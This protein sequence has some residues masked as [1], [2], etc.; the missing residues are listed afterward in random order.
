MSD[1][2][3]YDLLLVGGSSSNLILAHRLL[4]LAKLSGLKISIAILEK[5]R[6]FGGHIISGAI[7]NPQVIARLFPDFESQGFPHEGRVEVSHLSVLGSQERWDLPEAAIPKGLRKQGQFI[8]T[9]S[10]VIRWLAETLQ[11]KAKGIPNVTLDVF[12]GFAAHEILYE[13]ERVI[14]VRVSDS[15]QVYE[16]CVF[17]ELT[18]FGDKGFISKDLVEKFHLRPRP[19]LWSVGVKELWQIPRSLQGQVWHTLGY[20]VLDGSFSGGFVYGLKDNRLALGLIIGLDSKNPNLNPQQRLQEFKAHPWIQSLIAGGKLLKY[21]AAVIPEGGYYSLPSRFGVEG[22]LLLGDALGVLDVGSLAGINNAM[23][24]GYLAAGLIHDGFLKGDLRIQEAY[25]KAV[26]ESSV[27]QDLYRSRYFR[28]AFLENSRLLEEYLPQICRSVDAGHPWLG[29]LRWGLQDP[30][31]RGGEL[32][33]AYTLLTGRVSA[34]EPPPRGYVAPHAAIQADFVAP[35][36]LDP[37]ALTTRWGYFSRSDAVFFADPRYPEGN[38]HILEFSADTCRQ[39]IAT[40]DKLNRP[41]PCVADCT[42]EV[43]H[44]REHN[45]IRS[46]A[47]SLE[48]CIQCRTCEI[49][50]PHL[51]LRVNPSYEGSGPDFYGL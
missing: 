30:V 34:G 9:L 17:A 26:M 48:N 46:H 43:H 3:R 47:M 5:A 25:Q 39:C 6:Q 33:R 28:E 21:G 36:G 31:R 13:G 2:I 35:L 10:H 16:D 15:G 49:V 20:P 32:L 24:T 45:G 7:C 41:T 40:Y 37:E 42:A 19:Q 11:E 8:L 22:A 38:R 4:D 12:P 18:C 14:G 27:G 50:C 51:N 44:I 1:A 23:E 29:S